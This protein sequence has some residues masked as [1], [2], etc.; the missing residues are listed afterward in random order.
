MVLVKGSYR[1]DWNSFGDDSLS[2]TYGQPFMAN[3]GILWLKV[4]PKMP[5]PI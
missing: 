4:I 2:I 3:K 1:V 5:I